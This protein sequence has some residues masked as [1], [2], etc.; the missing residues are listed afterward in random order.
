MGDSEKMMNAECSVC[1]S[2]PFTDGVQ[3]YRN[4]PPGEKTEWRCWEHL[5]PKWQEK[6]LMFLTEECSN[7]NT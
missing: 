5:D 1:G 2:G 4:G 6:Q 7:E 3:L